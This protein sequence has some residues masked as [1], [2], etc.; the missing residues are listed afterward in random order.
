MVTHALKF[1]H[2]DAKGTS[3]YANSHSFCRDSDLN[4]K[5]LSTASLNTFEVD[6]VCNARVL[7]VVNLLILKQENRSLIDF[8]AQNDDSALKP[9]ATSPEQLQQWMNDFSEV[10]LSKELSS[11]TLAKQVFFPINA[12]EYHLLGPLFASSLAQ[13]LHHRIIEQRFS[14]TAKEARKA[15]R[16]EKYH[17]AVISD[18]PDMAIQNFGGTKPRNVSQLNVKR[19][20]S[21]YLFSCAPPHWNKQHKSLP[22][23][24][25]S[26]FKGQYQYRTKE[27]INQFRSYLIA[28]APKDS[29]LPLRDRRQ[30]YVEELVNSMLDYAAE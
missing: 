5:Y 16:E 20:G 10:L 4:A 15:R 26:I 13:E 18:F 28:I 23:R 17:E 14:E 1:T 25:K 29:T 8:I 7:D 19:G 11:H 27:S 6:Y 9:F 3:I 12:T 24:E 21:V 22:T 30:E 2:T